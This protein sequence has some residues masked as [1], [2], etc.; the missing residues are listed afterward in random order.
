[1]AARH[2]VTVLQP[3]RSTRSHD[4]D[5]L[6][7][8]GQITFEHMQ[9]I[10]HAGTIT[11]LWCWALPDTVNETDGCIH[12]CCTVYYGTIAAYVVVLLTVG[13][14]QALENAIGILGMLRVHFLVDRLFEDFFELFPRFI[15]STMMQHDAS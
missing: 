3:T 5:H 12:Q 11:P 7:D 2:T 6:V 1:M 8:A 10:D 14:S 9:C 15:S 13:W 4:R